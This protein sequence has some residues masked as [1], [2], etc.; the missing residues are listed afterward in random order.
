[1]A[2]PPDGGS[3]MQPCTTTAPQ[4]AGHFVTATFWFPAH[5]P[6]VKIAISSALTPP[7]A[8][9]L[10]VPAIIAANALEVEDE[11]GANGAADGTLAFLAIGT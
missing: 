3:P 8:A 1:M 2:M 9:R 6:S 4:P 10:D 5:A 7:F 11:A